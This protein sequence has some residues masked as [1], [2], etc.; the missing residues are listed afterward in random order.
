M[1]FERVR[2]GAALAVAHAIALLVPLLGACGTPG[3]D[4]PTLKEGLYSVTSDC[5]GATSAE[6]VSKLKSSSRWNE[7]EGDY[8]LENAPD[9]GMPSQRL[10][11]GG[12]HKLVSGESGGEGGACMAMLFTH[13]ATSALFACHDGGEVRCTVRLSRKGD[14]E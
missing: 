13:D 4:D 9:Y 5:P 3:V 8:D 7:V 10:D 2:A 14:L 6:G 12:P 11:H 1:C